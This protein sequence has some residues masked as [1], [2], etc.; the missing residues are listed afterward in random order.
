MMTHLPE[1][2]ARLRAA[3]IEDPD[4]IVFHSYRIVE[5]LERSDDH[6]AAVRTIL[7]F[8]EDNPSLDY[9]V[10]GPLVHYIERFGGSYEAELFASLSRRPT[11]YTVWML[12]RMI[13]GAKTADDR[14]RL[15]ARLEA[16]AAHE[17]ADADMRE[18]VADFLELKRHRPDAG[19]N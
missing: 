10:P 15:L 7:K 4:H 5:D 16:V 12:K 18:L 17:A 6:L 3:A 14:A 13:N 11:Y 2:E 9:G 1:L 19:H 8:M